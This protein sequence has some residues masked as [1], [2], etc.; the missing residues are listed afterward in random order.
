MKH[1]FTSKVTVLPQKLTKLAT[2]AIFAITSFAAN[3]ESFNFSY[4]FENTGNGSP[5][6]VTGSFTGDESG[7][8]VNNISNLHVFLNGSEFSG[9]LFT[10][11]WNT[12]TH[13]WDNTSAPIISFDSAKN[14]FIF[15]DTN[16]PTNFNASNYF[17]MTN[18]ASDPS[19]TPHEAFAINYNVS[20]ANGNALSGDDTPI[21]KS[22]SLTVA[23]AV[24]EPESYAM[25]IIGF[26]LTR[27]ALRRKQSS[28][29]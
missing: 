6:T 9:P 27:L 21:N 29:H 13:S 1:Q 15:A 20:D 23:S 14:N 7:L 5:L 22:W 8:F 17:Y 25:L 24:P 11:A 28:A 2:L 26:A 4:S 16:V 19:G 10:A 3:A 18:D 12:T